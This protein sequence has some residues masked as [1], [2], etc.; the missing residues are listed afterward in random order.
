MKNLYTLFLISPMAM[1][2]S[3]F[4]TQNMGKSAYISYDK[5]Y[6]K[7][8]GIDSIAIIAITADT[9]KAVYEKAVNKIQSS[10]SAAGIY[11]INSFFSPEEGAQA[12]NRKI[13]QIAM[14]VRLV[15][16]PVASSYQLDELN[17]TF[18]VKQIPCF[19]QKNTGE[20]IADFSV[21]IDREAS[22]DKTGGDV[23]AV[24]LAYLKKKNFIK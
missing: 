5:V 22:I 4:S 12:V 3:C 18:Y 2:Y 16:N 14:P 23:A 24:M 13:N 8:T 9:S 20:H 21:R 7:H 15:M 1:L 6:I 19:L 11:N 17:N 10:F